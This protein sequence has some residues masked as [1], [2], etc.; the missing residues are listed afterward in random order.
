[1]DHIYS[2]TD[3]WNQS[4]D[5]L[6]AWTPVNSDSKIPRVGNTTNV[7]HP[8]DIYL[9][10]GSFFRLN[11]LQLSYSLHPVLTQKIKLKKLLFYV[12][13]QNLFTITKYPGMEPEI[14]LNTYRSGQLTLGSDGGTFPQPRT[15]LIGIK[16]KI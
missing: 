11:R 5:M 8:S 3:S 13:V 7:R 4:R 9:F 16:I 10:N 12:S 15:F 6:H 14:G 2:G 1:M